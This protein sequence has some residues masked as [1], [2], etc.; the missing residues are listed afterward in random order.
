[1]N[2]VDVSNVNLEDLPAYQEQSDGPLMPPT[3]VAAAA[4]TA[5]QQQGA[6]SSQQQQQFQRD[7]GIAVRDERPRQKGGEDAYSAPNE[8]PPGYEEAQMAGLQDEMDKRA[9]DGAKR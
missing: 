6:R 9:N 7:S 3:A 5:Q 8:P 2:G 1:M 4:A